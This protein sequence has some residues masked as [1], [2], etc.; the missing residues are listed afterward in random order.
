MRCLP[1][2]F[3][4]NVLLPQL[5]NRSR[6]GRRFRGHAGS[7]CLLDTICQALTMAVSKYTGCM[8]LAWEP[9]Q[10]GNAT[11]GSCLVRWEK[12]ALRHMGMHGRSMSLLHSP[13]VHPM[14]RGRSRTPPGAFLLCVVIK[15]NIQSFCSRETWPN[16][17][18]S[19]LQSSALQQRLWTVTPFTSITTF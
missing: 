10:G 2:L 9:L 5:K 1:P 16:I 19:A 17:R 11:S 3:S 13:T 6:F 14:T 12:L 18:T 4:T 7:C 8:T 15:L